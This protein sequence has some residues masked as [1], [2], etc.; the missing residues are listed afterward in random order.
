VYGSAVDTIVRPPQTN[1]LELAAAPRRRRWPWLGLVVL[2]TIVLV[3]GSIWIANYVPLAQGSSGFGT[4]RSD[5]HVTNIDAFDISGVVFDVQVGRE[6][7]FRYRFSIRNAGPLAVTIHAVG[8]QDTGGSADLGRRAVRVNDDPYTNTSS[9]E[10]WH[11]FALAPG[12]EALIEME[13]VYRGRCLGEGD[14]MFWNRE[15][16]TYSILGLPRHEDVMVGVE[17]RF[18]GTGD[19]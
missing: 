4:L 15:P 17:V 14:A 3:V 6:V 18:V 16:V 9:F 7:T 11:S 13:A 10:P 8:G 19:C 12:D 1:D 2:V 5:V